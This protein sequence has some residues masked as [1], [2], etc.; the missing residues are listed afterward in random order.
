M[1]EGFFY[2]TGKLRYSKEAVS[3]FRK[4]R[5]TNQNILKISK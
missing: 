2:Y 3:G 1:L 4:T 5:K